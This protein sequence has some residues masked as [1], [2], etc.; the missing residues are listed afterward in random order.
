[1]GYFGHCARYPPDRW[2]EHAIAGTVVGWN[3]GSAKKTWQK[4]VRADFERLNASWYECCDR[5]TWRAVL[6]GEIV[7]T[8]AEGPT[9]GSMQTAHSNTRRH[10]SNKVTQVRIIEEV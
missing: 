9:A 6:D 10:R 1:M 5:V 4:S 2:V 3:G 7:L 8:R